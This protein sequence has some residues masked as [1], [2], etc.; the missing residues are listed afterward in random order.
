M[1]EEDDPNEMSPTDNGQ[2]LEAF[3]PGP[4]PTFG[5]ITQSPDR[6]LDHIWFGKGAAFKARAFEAA[7]QLVSAL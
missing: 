2:S 5:V 1:S 6:R 4:L 7:Q 3:A